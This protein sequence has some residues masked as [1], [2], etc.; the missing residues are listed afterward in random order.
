MTATGSIQTNFETDSTIINHPGIDQKRLSEARKILE[1]GDAILYKPTRAGFTT[2]AVYAALD[3]KKRTLFVAPTNRILKET[4]CAAGMGNSVQVLP[5]C[6][7]LRLR[8]RIM[9]DRFLSQL[10]LLLP[11]CDECD[12]LKRCPVTKIL[13][14]ESP[15]I[16]ITYRKLEALMLSKSKIAKEILNKISSVDAIV[17]DEAHEISLQ[18]VVRVP[19]FYDLDLPT[20]YP[21]LVNSF[22]KWRDLD[23]EFEE[24]INNLRQV[25]DAGHVGKH[26][27]STI[28]NDDPLNVKQL[29]AGYDELYELANHRKELGVAEKDILALRDILSILSGCVVGIFIHE[30]AK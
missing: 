12:E 2:S 1:A 18:K 23:S 28:S 8:D 24:K 6:F 5:N 3:I 7:C 22:V 21:N 14:D 29:I 19:A 11:K 30:R 17:M 16:G 10:P 9:E 25:G 26:L 4:I 27:S 13:A 15:V 20:T